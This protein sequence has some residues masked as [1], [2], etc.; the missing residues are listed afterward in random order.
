M[1]RNRKRWVEWMQGSARGQAI[2]DDE[3]LAKLNAVTH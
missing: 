2:D 3:D 1:A